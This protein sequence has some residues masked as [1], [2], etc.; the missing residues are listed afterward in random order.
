MSSDSGLGQDSFDHSQ[1]SG[2]SFGLSNLCLT[3]ESTT[4]IS[5]KSMDLCNIC[6]L[7]P[8]N[9]VFN[10]R[11]IGHRYCCYLC[12]KKI[13]AKTGRCPVCKLKIRYVTKIIFV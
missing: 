4:D 10:H 5:K 13:W 2:G 1:E 6:L 8:K 7:K 3:Q 12:A 11:K 9:G